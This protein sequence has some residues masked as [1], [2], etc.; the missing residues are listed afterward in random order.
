MP[1]PSSCD[2][3]LFDV[4]GTLLHVHRDPQEAALERIAHLGRVS[5]EAFRVG[6]HEAVAEWHRNGGEPHQEDLADTWVLHY[7]RALTSAQF[8]GDRTVAARL[9]EASFLI[10]GWAVF[11][12]AIPVLDALRARNMTL[13][14]ISNWPP[15]LEYTLEQAGL[16]KYFS[17]VV[18]SGVVGYAKPHP[19]IFHLA[20]DSLGVK[21]ERLVYVGDDLEHDVV[22]ATRAGWR[23][24]LLDR[25]NRYP[26][27]PGRI[28]SL[29]EVEAL[30][31]STPSREQPNER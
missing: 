2:A 26:T 25:R 23:A 1:A 8:P 28:S 22:G 3:V 10:D 30:L 13:G 7:E 31:D 5:L 27:H 20:A 18:S 6:V 4:G 21:A 11:P 15:T 12:D 16:H 9:M 19:Q 17:V 14:I 29:G 24:I